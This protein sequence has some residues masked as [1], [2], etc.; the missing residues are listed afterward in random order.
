MRFRVRPAFLGFVVLF[1][2]A[3]SIQLVDHNGTGTLI[4]AVALAIFCLLTRWLTDDDSAGSV[5]K[6]R[7]LAL[8]IAVCTIIFF[9]TLLEGMRFNHVAGAGLRT[10]GFSNARDAILAAISSHMPFDIANGIANFIIYCIP[11]AVLLS[12]LRVPLSQQGL[13]R[14]RR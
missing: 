13:G 14:F 8:Q 1:A 12:L 2:I 5:R 6:P 4:T 7:L 11:I 9:A 3:E 10:P